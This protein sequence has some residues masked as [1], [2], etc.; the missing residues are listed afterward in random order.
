[1]NLESL[2]FQLVQPLCLFIHRN[3]PHRASGAVQKSSRLHMRNNG[4]QGPR[5]RVGNKRWRGCKA[6]ERMRRGTAFLGCS[7]ELYRLAAVLHA[8]SSN[9]FASYS[10]MLQFNVAVAL[11]G[12]VPA[13]I[14][15]F[16]G[17]MQY[18]LS[19]LF[20]LMGY[21]THPWE[22]VGRCQHSPLLL[23]HKCVSVSK[24]VCLMFCVN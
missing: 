5:A 15:I 16:P 20:Y 11:C 12:A 4:I 3:P 19:Q 1:M 21:A 22:W 8:K 13:K 24:A 17:P 10:V 7:S 6:E 23:I 2:R 18:I 9:S 14:S